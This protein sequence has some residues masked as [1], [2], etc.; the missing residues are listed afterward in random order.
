MTQK[1]KRTGNDSSGEGSALELVNEGSNGR[2]GESNSSSGQSAEERGED[3]GGESSSSGLG[4]TIRVIS[5][6]STKE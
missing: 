1:D 2:G 6:W 4:D 5:L 3:V